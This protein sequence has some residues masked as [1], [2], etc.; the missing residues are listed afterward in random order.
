VR[1]FEVVIFGAYYV[2]VFSHKVLQALFVNNESL[3]KMYLNHSNFRLCLLLKEVITHLIR[4][5]T[6]H[7]GH[8][9]CLL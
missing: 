1:P 3:S 4:T 2:P 9:N 8:L 5:K 6:Q 7:L